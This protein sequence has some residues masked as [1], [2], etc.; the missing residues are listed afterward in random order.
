MEFGSVIDFI[1]T[2]VEM[3]E[4]QNAQNN[5]GGNNKKDKMNIKKESFSYG[6][7]D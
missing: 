1:I 6:R 4:K 5:N 2:H 7:A 3:Q